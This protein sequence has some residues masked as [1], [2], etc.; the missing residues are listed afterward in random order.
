[1]KEQYNK[2]YADDS[3]IG[4]PRKEKKRNEL[5]RILTRDSSFQIF[6]SPPSAYRLK[7]EYIRKS[8]LLPR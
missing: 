5:P 1:M 8:F 3:R 4:T 2:N 6:G 7:H